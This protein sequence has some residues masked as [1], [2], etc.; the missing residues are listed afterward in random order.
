MEKKI[1][2]ISGGIVGLSTAMQ[3]L[4]RFP[5]A[6]VTVLEKEVAIAGHQTGLLPTDQ[7]G[8]LIVASDA[9][10]LQRLDALYD[11]CLK[12]DLLPER[13]SRKSTVVPVSPRTL[14]ARTKSDDT[15]LAATARETRTML[16]LYRSGRSSP[17]G[18]I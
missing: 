9:V 11:R 4:N 2:V 8:K 18:T 5:Q 10:G 13:I 12:N 16:V 3:F 6:Q 7:R 14:A 1:I 15:T 17:P